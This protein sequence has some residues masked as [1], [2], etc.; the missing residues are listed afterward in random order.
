M[1]TCPP[2]IRSQPHFSTPRVF[3]RLSITECCRYDRISVDG[4]AIASP[5]SGSCSVFPHF[6]EQ[7]FSTKPHRRRD[8][9]S[10][11]RPSARHIDRMLSKRTSSGWPL[12]GAFLLCRQFES[13]VTAQWHYQGSFHTRQDMSTKLNK[14]T[15]PPDSSYDSGKY[16][17]LHIHMYMYSKIQPV[18]F[19]SRTSVDLHG[20]WLTL[21]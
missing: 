10:T 1:P 6:H 4:R 15:S 18:M 13:V 8:L 7:V 2:H 20:L 9:F 14:S 11:W 17:V 16:D 21:E 3:K 5:C 12:T 19:K